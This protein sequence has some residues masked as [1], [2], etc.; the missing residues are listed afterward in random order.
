MHTITDAQD[1]NSGSQD[2][3]IAFWR[4]AVVDRAGAAG[5]HN[6]GWFELQDFF[7]VRGAGYN[8]TE[9]SLFANAASNQLGVLPAKIEHHDTAK[10][11]LRFAAFLLHFGS[12]LDF[13]HRR[14]APAAS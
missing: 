13:R 8:R 12:G 9:Y 5:E 2:A 4:V 10:L 1:W 7:Y 14:F 11:G 3:G 6:A